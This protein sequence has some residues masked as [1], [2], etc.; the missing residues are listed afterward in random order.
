MRR[1]R[2][3]GG[4]TAVA[5]VAAARLGVRCAYAGTLGHDENSDFVL[6]SLEAEGVNVEVALRRDGCE[7]V[8]SFIV[9]GESP[10][11]RTIFVD[12]SRHQGASDDAPS[13]EIIR[14][15]RVLFVDHYGVPGRLRAARIAQDAGIPVVADLETDEAPDFKQLLELCDPLILSLDFARRLSAQATPATVTAA[16]RRAK[17]YTV[18]LTDGARGCWFAGPGDSEVRHQPVFPDGVPRRKEVEDL[19]LK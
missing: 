16:L 1:A 8:R 4:V 17:N 19:L 13:A 14:A 3:Y 18:T 11:T 10:K 5:L 2:V 12:A 6:K 7:P 15:A 9:V